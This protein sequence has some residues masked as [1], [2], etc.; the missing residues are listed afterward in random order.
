MV[1]SC[2]FHGTFGGVHGAYMVLSWRF[3][4]TLRGRLWTLTGFHEL[5]WCTRCVFMDFH[6][7]SVASDGFHRVYMVLSWRF[8]GRHGAV[9]VLSWC[10]HGAL[11]CFHGALMVLSPVFMVRS[12]TAMARSRG[13]CAF[14]MFSWRFVFLW[15]FHGRDETSMDCHGLSWF[16]RLSWLHCAF[17]TSHGFHGSVMVLSCAHDITALSWCFHDAFMGLSWHFHGCSWCFMDYHGAFITF[18]GSHGAFMVF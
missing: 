15:G 4:G 18:R 10:F 1:H 7:A 12:W 3:H 13:P 2:C 11:W 14:M 17:M 8:I 5:S 9:S 6:S 16:H